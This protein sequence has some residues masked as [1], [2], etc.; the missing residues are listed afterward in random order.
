MYNGQVNNEIQFALNGF[1][2]AAAQPHQ[3]YNG[4]ILLTSHSHISM[5]NGSRLESSKEEA[6]GGIRM[7]WNF[8][9]AMCIEK[10]GM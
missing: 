9:R 1:I 4:Q 2:V 10:S 5:D 8:Q 7:R 6:L 3:F